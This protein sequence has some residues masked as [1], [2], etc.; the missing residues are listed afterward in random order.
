MISLFAG[1]KANAKA[2]R[3]SVTKLIHKIWIGNNTSIML[4]STI[5]NHFASS[6]VKRVAKNNTI[7]SPMLHDIKNCITFKPKSRF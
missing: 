1:S 5:P 7:T 3:E 6:G 4:E 2:G